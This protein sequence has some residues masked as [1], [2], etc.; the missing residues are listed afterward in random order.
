M[1]ECYVS[2]VAGIHSCN[3]T[4][5][6]PEIFSKSFQNLYNSYYYITPLDGY[7]RIYVLCHTGE[8]TCLY[9]CHFYVN[10]GDSDI[11]ITHEVASN[12]LYKTKQEQVREGISLLISILTFINSKLV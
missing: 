12:R 5:F 2:K 9:C 11:E 8:P 4:N 6:S 1:V 10:D 7:F 3:L